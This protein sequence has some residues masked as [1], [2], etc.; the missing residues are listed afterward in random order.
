MHNSHDVLMDVAFEGQATDVLPLRLRIP[1]DATWGS[2]YESVIKATSQHAEHVHMATERVDDLALGCT[3]TDADPQAG[4]LAE[5]SRVTP[6]ELDGHHD[7]VALLLASATTE[8][9]RRVWDIGMSTE[10]DKELI[11]RRWN[12]T[13]EPLADMTVA[14]AFERQAAATPGAVALESG[15]ETVSY[16]QLSSRASALAWRLSRAGVQPGDSVGILMGRSPDLVAALLAVAKCGA[17]YVPVDLRSPVP[18][19]R[20]IV[21][22]VGARTLV[23]D[24]STVDHPITAGLNLIQADIDDAGG[25]D[26]E[27]RPFPD[28]ASSSDALLYI[29]HTSGSTG[30]P[31]GAEI[32]HRNVLALALDSRLRGAAHERVLFHS[33]HAF[34]AS[35]YEI[36]APLLAGGRVVI[37]PD[38]VDAVQL[39]R[40]AGGG[41]ITAVFLT[42]G[43]LAA[44]AQGDPGCLRGVREV[45][46]GGEIVPPWA[47]DRIRD[48]SPGTTVINVY[49]PTENTTFSTCYPITGG[50]L[51]GRE[52]P[53]GAPMDNT[54]T[55]VLDDNLRL[56]PPGA[57]GQVYVA[58]AR[59]ARGYTGRP[60]LTA[61]SFLP[62][63]YGAPGSRM[64]ATGDLGSWDT[65]GQL[66]F[67]GRADHQ[68]K[69]HGFR[70]EP[71]EIES[72][73]LRHPRVSHAA[74]II[75]KQNENEGRIVAF[76]VLGADGEATDGKE[77]RGYVAE[78][79]PDYMV[80]AEV[81]LLPALP[82]NRNGKIDRSRLA[83]LA[84]AGSA[85]PATWPVT[86]TERM[87]RDM[88]EELLEL[89]VTSADASFWDLGGDSLLAFT[90][91]A[92]IRDRLGVEVRLRDVFQRPRVGDLASFI[93][94]AQAPD[95]E[96]PPT[97]AQT[98]LP[99]SEFQRQMWLAQKLAPV[100]G[101]YN[102]FHAWRVPGRLD[103]SRL[104]MAVARVIHRH[105]VLRTTFSE[106]VG[107]S[108]TQVI[109]P[110]WQPDIYQERCGDA[111]ELAVVLRAE[112]DAPLNLTT[113]PLLRVRLIDTVDGQVLTVTIHHI[114]FDAPSLTLFMGEVRRNYA[115]EIAEPEHESAPQQFR[116][117]I[118][119]LE[120][121][122]PAGL[123]RRVEQLRGAPSRL[124]LPTP[125]HVEPNGRIPLELP[126][127][128][129][130]RMRPLQER[131]GMSWF[132]V[133]AAALAAVLH[134]WT[135]MDDLTFGF[136][137]DIR[138]ER[139]F[140]TAMGP[141]LNML[142]V[143]SRCSQSTT[144]SELLAATRD[145]IL[146]ALEDQ[147]V[148]FEA[149][150]TQ[151]NPQRS[152]GSTPYLDVILAPQ[153]RPAPFD[154]AGLRLSQIP[155]PDGAATIGKFTVAVPLEVVD[156]KLTGTL[157]YRGDRLPAARATGL[158]RQFAHA[159]ELFV[160]HPGRTIGTI[161]LA[162]L[163]DE[164][165][166]PALAGHERPAAATSAPPGGSGR[167]AAAREDPRARI[168]AI[169]SSIV[170]SDQVGPDDNFFDCGG[171]SL[172]LV[173]LH[174]EL[175]RD[176][177]RELPIELLIDN[178]TISAMTRLLAEGA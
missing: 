120:Q 124:H 176:F 127:D 69:L 151:L 3:F 171:N 135:G 97:A 26:G 90:L 44:L 46:T 100:P 161:E 38:K 72:V 84:T 85:G 31:K 22:A 143:R 70:I 67:R 105:E 145:R 30:E 5:S 108:L 107:G 65:N 134:R 142:V 57:I 149:V 9:D 144:V 16:S 110:P 94:A 8:Q 37:S 58:G 78:Q 42:S 132:M 18:R 33:P 139:A 147:D 79:L 12:D 61:G 173:T 71:G 82:L 116:E 137:A 122:D 154:I 133:S 99:A 73:L 55:Y 104:A 21:H 54:R 92:R 113:G 14:Q 95:G 163:D 130:Q 24:H 162:H 43:L 53:I 29:M 7:R 114:V 45:W 115:S 32:S 6:F 88:W 141:C 111:D 62:D 146:E 20:A 10:K 51:E 103:R 164:S 167:P 87:L 131:N 34:D 41:A 109:G 150:V 165:R 81:T 19:M 177:D 83:E 178:P 119:I 117:L 47:V 13:D 39:R 89:P 126:D 129:L 98:E 169:W 15:R 2:V 96:Q 174:A 121:V 80:P 168:T 123:D 156:D 112:A 64:Y 125:P 153:A 172:K 66:R 159:L 160:D 157:I 76:A 136:G 4:L 86:A 23:T 152:A 93:D 140:A 128:L 25:A 101:L 35:T 17:T 49:G 148:P 74:V 75:H 11:L 77:L 1:S 40:L 138:P 155:T 50:P 28:V 63:P 106:G 56:V 59:V 166:E 36:W 102:A 27:A 48:A 68:V 52:L 158:A 91:A 170:E 118:P 175:C 60:G